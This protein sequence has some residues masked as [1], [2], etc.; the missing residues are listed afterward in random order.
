M[1]IKL[2]RSESDPWPVERHSHASCCLG[3]GGKQPQLLVTGGTGRDK[4]ILSDAWLFDL[5]SRKW[6][7]VRTL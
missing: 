7:E 3:F 2:P 1:I 4:K 6:K 5:S